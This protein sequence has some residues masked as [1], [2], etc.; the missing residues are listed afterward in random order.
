MASGYPLQINGVRILTTEA[1]YQACRFPHMP[2]VQ[3]EI[4]GQLSPMT[5][6]MKSKPHRKHSRADWDDVRYNVM[7]WCLRV[8]LAQNYKEFG[9][10]LLATR[11]RPIV[12][13]SR[14]DDYWGA[15]LA[16]EAGEMLVGQNILGRLLMEL[17]EKLKDDIEAALKTVSPLRIPDFLLLGK[18]I[19]IVVARE[20][21]TAKVE[22]S[23]LF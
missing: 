10:L 20:I 7:R 14:T 6:K 21:N 11:D 4:I 15:K 2:E 23:A 8:K 16:D 9:R 13:Q 12:E 1:L 3:K 19:E 18:P 22:Q 17:R 5:A